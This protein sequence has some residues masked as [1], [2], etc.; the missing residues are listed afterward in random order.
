MNAA[1]SGFCLARLPVVDLAA[2]GK[3]SMKKKN[4][5]IYNSAYE[6]GF[7]DAMQRAAADRPKRKPKTKRV[8]GDKPSIAASEAPTA[9][10]PKRNDFALVIGLLAGIFGLWGV[11]HVLNN[12]VV[13][14]C[15]FLLVIRG[16]LPRVWAGYRDYRVREFISLRRFSDLAAACLRP[17][18]RRRESGLSPFTGPATMVAATIK[19]KKTRFHWT[20]AR[21]KIV[22]AYIF[23]AIPIVFFAYIRIYPT[24]FAFQMSLHDYNPM[25]VEQPYVGMENYQKVFEDLGKR[26][27]TTKSAFQNTISYVLFGVPIQLC[28]ALAI[29]LMLNEIRFMSTTVSHSVFPALRDIHHRHRMGLPHVVSAALWAIQCRLAAGVIAAAAFPAQPAASLAIDPGTGDMAGHGLRGDHFPGRFEADFAH[30]L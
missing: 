29:A 4:E 9:E 13:P 27:S 19:R 30:L 12:K 6:A 11:A 26:K 2:D 24:I 28:L 8:V 25:A 16:L 23:L 5:S 3:I 15:V 22:W 1:A 7:R 17:S 18:Q 20:L 21:R 14:G 10:P